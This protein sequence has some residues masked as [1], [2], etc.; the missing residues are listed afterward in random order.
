MKIVQGKKAGLAQTKT[1][2]TPT[3]A[4][5]WQHTSTGKYAGFQYKYQVCPGLLP[6]HLKRQG[7]TT[8]P[9]RTEVTTDSSPSYINNTKYMTR[10]RS[11][12]G[13]SAVTEAVH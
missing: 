13:Q 7:D 1:V 6:Q 2:D 10:D 9:Q 11:Q 12:V 5:K 4:D 8:K 3:D